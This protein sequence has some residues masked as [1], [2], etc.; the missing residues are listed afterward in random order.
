MAGLRVLEDPGA[1]RRA[2]ANLLAQGLLDGMPEGKIP[3]SVPGAAAA[4][5]AAAAVRV[6]NCAPTRDGA[7]GAG[8]RTR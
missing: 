1:V 3:F 7:D 2:A 5:V 8:E 6:R 4:A